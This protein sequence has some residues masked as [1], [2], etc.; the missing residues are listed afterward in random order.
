M[1]TL[2]R[3]QEELITK[4]HLDTLEEASNGGPVSDEEA[5]A[6]ARDVY[7]HILNMEF[8]KEIVVTDSPI[9]CHKAFKKLLIKHKLL[10]TGDTLPFVWPYID[11]LLTTSYCT[12]VRALKA[13]GKKVPKSF[14]VY[15]QTIKIGLLYPLEQ[16]CVI[17]SRPL[18]IKQN[19]QG[20][21]HCDGGPAVEYRDGYKLYMLNGVKVTEEL[22]CTPSEKIDPGTILTEKNVEVRREILR[23]VGAERL[24][25]KLKSKVVDAVDEYELHRIPLGGQTKA[26]ALKMHNPSVPEVWHVEFVPESTATVQEALNFRNGLTP[27]MIDDVNGADWYQQGDVIMRPKG[28]KKFKSRP[29]RLT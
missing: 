28:A 13:L 6:V 17:G 20:Q 9:S 10:G 25:F 23:K 16:F 5:I 1:D 11:G 2:T 3:E 24:L 12:M 15:E 7:E 27:D 8:P 22:A 29:K 19:A 4:V 21:L 26:M 14:E 18:Y